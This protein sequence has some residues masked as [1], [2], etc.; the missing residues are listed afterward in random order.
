MAKK[1]YKKSLNNIKKNIQIFL[2]KKN[3]KKQQ[4]G[5]KRYKYLLEDEKQKLV[6]PIKSGLFWACVSTGGHF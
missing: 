4:Y 3:K 5:H 1:E 6:K 2:K